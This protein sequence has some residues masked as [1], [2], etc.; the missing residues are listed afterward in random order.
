MSA[1]RAFTEEMVGAEPAIQVSPIVVEQ[2]ADAG[3]LR[4]LGM[5]AAPE[6]GRLR[7]AAPPLAKRKVDYDD[8]DEEEDEFEDYEDEDDY[9]EDE[10]EDE[11][12]FDEYDDEDDFDDDDFEDEDF[13]DEFDDD[14]DEDPLN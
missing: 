11:D 8:D 7:L 5:L 6:A 3:G 1:L 2:L 4:S 13:D 14:D 12:D 10:F 9:E